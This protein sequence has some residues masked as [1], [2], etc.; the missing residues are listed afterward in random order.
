[1]FEDVGGGCLLQGGC[2]KNSVKRIIVTLYLQNKTDVKAFQ[3]RQQQ[4]LYANHLDVHQMDK[5]ASIS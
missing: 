5:H 3:Q 2:P 1:M 4:Q